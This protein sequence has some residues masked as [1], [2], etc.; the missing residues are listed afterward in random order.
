MRSSGALFNLPPALT[1]EVLVAS[2]SADLPKCV[3]ATTGTAGFTTKA[4]SFTPGAQTNARNS[5]GGVFLFP[6]V[7]QFCIVRV[8]GVTELGLRLFETAL[9]KLSAEARCHHKRQTWQF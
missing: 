5:L 7:L 9:A 8:L 6:V 1:V 2:R 3:L 4:S